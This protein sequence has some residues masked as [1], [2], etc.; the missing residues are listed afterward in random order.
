MNNSF[1][2]FPKGEDV[3]IPDHFSPI[4][5][6]SNYTLYAQPES[7]EQFGDITIIIDGNPLPRNYWYSEYGQRKK[8]KLV[9]DLFSKFGTSFIT[10]IKGFFLIVIFTKDS[11]YVYNDIHSVK[12]FYFNCKNSRI[13]LS[14][15][16][17]LL[18][19]NLDTKIDDN[20]AIHQSL[21]QHFLFGQTIFE[22][23]KY[24]EY[25]SFAT[26]VESRLTISKY[27][28]VDELI[29]DRQNTSNEEFTIV[30]NNTIH[31]YIKY[32]NPNHIAITITGGRDTRS[33]L[34][35]LINN[36]N[37]PH[38]FTFG[39]PQNR[40]VV[41]GKLIAQT[42]GLTFSNPWL[43]NPS[44]NRYKLLTEEIINNKNP[45]VNIHRA[46]R[47]DAIKKETENKNIDMLFLGAMGGDYIKGTAFDNYI[48]SEF[49]A[50]FFF[51]K[52]I[53]TE[54]II[55]E[56]LDKHSVI[57]TEENIQKIINTLQNSEIFK[58][59]RFTSK[60][61]LLIIHEIIGCSHDV[62]DIMVYFNYVSYVMAPF[63]DID[64][65]E[66]LFRTRFSLKT[67]SKNSL[68]PIARYLGGELQAKL[69][70]ALCPALKDIPFASYY[71]PSD[72]AGSKIK[73]I[74][75][76]SL[77]AYKHHKSHNISGFSYEEWFINYINQEYDDLHSSLADAYDIRKLKNL[78]AGMN[79][80][81]EEGYWHK[82]TNPLM[83]SSY[84]S[85]L[86]IR[87]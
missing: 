13:S 83:L 6:N 39:N 21:F 48:V 31:N 17:D 40:D 4:S 80:S 74:I 28:T 19:K 71:T 35:S 68:N 10:K 23:I 42:C 61:D 86:N 66:A 54:K 41:V 50:R 1:I 27:W 20:I 52:Q 79:H 87:K 81:K 69:I 78:L 56:I 85:K 55:S 84:C 70:L 59:R 73:Y 58:D 3:N 38:T 44:Y 57:H 7:K 46:H 47:L 14:N 22:N 64:I 77:A 32:F 65:I 18:K 2:I 12:R 16:L 33:V 45:F 37:L 75:K 8:G 76:R 72:A 25:A 30:F 49:I 26:L 9:Y 43:D 5:N 63:M 82:F 24:S 11:F 62:Q 51:D 15:D 60:K 36:G 34:A 67:N 53:K 29:S